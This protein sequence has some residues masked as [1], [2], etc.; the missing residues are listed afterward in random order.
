MPVA[1]TSSGTRVRVP[2]KVNLHLAVGAA[3]SDGFHEI[4]TVYQ[5]VSLY[6]ELT[7]QPGQPGGGITLA[8]SG[9]TSAGVPTGPENLAWRAAA[10]LAEHTGVTADVHLELDKTI[11]VAGGMAGGSAD[12]AAALLACAGL[13]RTGSGKAEL[14]ELA[15][16][17]GSDVAFPLLGGTAM[18]IGRGEQL[19]P[20]L[21]TGSFHWV[22]A[23]AD[24]GI[25]AGEAYRELDRLREAG[26]APEPVGSSDALL[27]ALRSGSCER[28]APTLANDL[29]AA[30][31]SLRPELDDVL[32][33]GLEAGAMAAMISG[34]GPTCAFLV[35]DDDAAQELSLILDKKSRRHSTRVAIAPVSGAR[36]LV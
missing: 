6:D 29:Q 9:P 15:A 34:S 10:L 12:A 32:A 36:V 23:M 35:C 7:A 33:T 8:T 21:A 4:A 19:T 16:D 13:W 5:A 14:L 22:F 20:V 1:D 24:F 11:P 3:R 17:L 25:S 2:A 18:G 30:A 26:E 31:L 27:D 28:L